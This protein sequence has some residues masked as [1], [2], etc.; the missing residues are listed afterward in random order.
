MKLNKNTTPVQRSGIETESTFTIKTSASAFE[1]L[2]SGLY[3]DAVG[4]I[5]RELAS[6]AFDSHR[7]ANKHDI[8]FD[9]HVPNGLEPWFSIRD[10]GTGLSHQD[11]L[12][13]YTTYFNSTKSDSNDFIGALGL[14]SKSPFAYSSDFQV[15]T[16][17]D[18]IKYMYAIFLNDD[19]VPSV[20]LMAESPTTEPNGLEVRLPSDDRRL[21]TVAISKYLAYFDVKPNILGLSADDVDN[22]YTDVRLPIGSTMDVAD[23][24]FITD[25]TNNSNYHISRVGVVYGQVPYPL[26][27]ESVANDITDF[28]SIDEINFFRMFSKRIV[29]IFSVGELSITANREE[30]KYD[31]TTLMAIASRITE[32]YTLFFLSVSNSIDTFPNNDSLY[33]INRYLME[34]VFNGE[35]DFFNAIDF[36]RINNEEF[37]KLDTM[38]AGHHNQS[39]F[40]RTVGSAVNRVHPKYYQPR[41]L[42]SYFDKTTG[43]ERSRLKTSG[44]YCCLGINAPVVYYV[45]DEGRLGISKIRQHYEKSGKSNEYN[46]VLQAVDSKKASPNELID[47][48]AAIKKELGN[49]DFILSSTL[50]YTPPAKAQ[51]TGSKKQLGTVFN[52]A[53]YWMPKNDLDFNAGGIYIYLAGG[54]KM[55]KNSTA[56]NEN[57]LFD[58]GITDSATIERMLDIYNTANST[59]FD[60][61][62]LIGVSAADIRNFDKAPNWTNIT[63]TVDSYIKQHQKVLHKAVETAISVQNNITVFGNNFRSDPIIGHIEKLVKTMAEQTDVM[64]IFNKIDTSSP[65]YNN[66]KYYN[67]TI[68]ANKHSIAEVTGIENLLRAFADN[69]YARP[70]VDPNNTEYSVNFDQISTELRVLYPMFQLLDQYYCDYSYLDILQLVIDYVSLIDRTIQN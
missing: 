37:K 38:R 59:L 15:T 65:Y 21:F 9:I 56:T 5:V 8:P 20:A 60:K 6:N 61:F 55:Y 3:S 2:S 13:I 67:D 49:P 19:K 57:D 47:E 70:R 1:I 41:Y 33:K 58:G 42:T 28:C 36:G 4:A 44:S 45:I 18:G 12:D 17:F 68:V 32:F 66:V 14:G 46:I 16:W 31:E 39:R 40:S 54:K 35:S 24:W 10:Y 64:D 62:D 51:R 23:K 43:E 25:A 52:R 27:V 11:V 50:E 22:L 7:A 26:Q 48:L 30:L 34:D 29:F 63:H 53:P 69:E